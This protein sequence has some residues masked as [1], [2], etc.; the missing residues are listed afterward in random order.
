MNM[1]THSGI[2]YH[3]RLIIKIFKLTYTVGGNRKRNKLKLTLDARDEYLRVNEVSLLSLAS[4][5]EFRK[6]AIVLESNSLN[7]FNKAQY[8]SGG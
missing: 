6:M 5:L 1:P 7:V 2:M 8:Y 3:M 4:L